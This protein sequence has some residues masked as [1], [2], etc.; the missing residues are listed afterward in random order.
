MERGNLCPRSL[1]FL[2]LIFLVKLFEIYTVSKSWNKIFSKYSQ[3]KKL[4]SITVCE[5]KCH[6]YR[7]LP[8]RQTCDVERCG[9]ILQKVDNM[10]MN[11]G[12]FIKLTHM[13]S[14]LLW[15]Y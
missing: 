3:H 8:V 2:S 1:I 14:C 13:F 11:L 6:T 4:N 9:I 12:E 5:R 15:S 7:N 10:A